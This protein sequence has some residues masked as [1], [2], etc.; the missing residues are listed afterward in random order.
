MSA[1]GQQQ[2]SNKSPTTHQH[3]NNMLPTCYMDL[4]ETNHAAA[5]NLSGDFV[6]KNTMAA[7]LGGGQVG[8]PSTVLATHITNMLPTCH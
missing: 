7:R 3:V 6:L 8:S 5:M 4:F 2:D 1:T